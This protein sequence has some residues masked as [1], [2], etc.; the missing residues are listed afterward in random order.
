MAKIFSEPVVQKPHSSSTQILKAV[1]KCYKNVFP[2]RKSADFWSLYSEYDLQAAL[3]YCHV[4]IV[5]PNAVSMGLFREHFT[6]Q[7]LKGGQMWLSSVIAFFTEFKK[8]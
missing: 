5:L 6:P 1:S 4:D 7:Y 8:S 3:L 2:S